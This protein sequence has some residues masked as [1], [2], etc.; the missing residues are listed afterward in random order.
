MGRKA[1]VHDSIRDSIKIDG[2]ISGFPDGFY[3]HQGAIGGHIGGTYLEH[4]TRMS[5]RKNMLVLDE[6]LYLA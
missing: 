4:Y 6:V 5:V 3:C 2:D 1:D